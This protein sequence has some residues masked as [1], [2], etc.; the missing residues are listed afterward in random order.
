MKKIKFSK[1]FI[2]AISILAF[3]GLLWIFLN[4]EMPEKTLAFDTKVGMTAIEREKDFEFICN[5]LEENMTALNEFNE[6]YNISFEDTKNKYQNLIKN[7]NSDYEYYIFLY[8]FFND[9]PSMHTG[10]RY[11]EIS[12]YIGGYNIINIDDNALSEA[13]SYWKNVTQSKNNLYKNEEIKTVSFNYLDGNY[14]SIKTDAPDYM[15]MSIEDYSKLISVNDIPIDDYAKSTLSS[16][17][18]QYD[19]KNNKAFRLAFLFNDKFGEECKI[20]YINENGDI[21]EEKVY[22]QIFGEQAIFS[23]TP[24]GNSDDL[25]SV[26][27]ENID[28][29]ADEVSCDS[30]YA[31][32]DTERNLAYIYVND[33]INHDGGK[34]KETIKNMSL[35]TDNIILDIRENPGGYAEY[36]EQNILSQLLDYDLEIKTVLNYKDTKENEILGVY[37]EDYA[38]NLRDSE[39]AGYKCFD[40]INS[41]KGEATKK[42]KLYLLVSSNTG[43][44]ADALTR[45]IK[46]ENL[47]T[48]IGTNTKGESNSSFILKKSE[49]SGLVFSYSPI[50]SYNADGTP[51][52]VYGTVPDFYSEVTFEN[53]KRLNSM[54]E[55]A[56]SYPIQITWDN[57]LMETIEKIK[58]M[59]D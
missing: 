10:L 57:V 20:K 7:C 24:S 26:V 45:I 55:E 14:Y 39:T 32:N 12:N 47:G 25:E 59:E 58:E 37:A 31:Y 43:S 35:E 34:L 1:G 19:L 13:V 4:M 38:N 50:I 21:F 48:I 36:F 53:Y 52:N 18:I 44:A 51:N 27:A 54:G 23:A 6:L 28:V 3:I 40:N 56:Y 29:S 30:F 22:G 46:D 2:I 16:F 11:P 42:I 9:I 17:K 8:S 33:F 5:H 41:I 49:V 15:K